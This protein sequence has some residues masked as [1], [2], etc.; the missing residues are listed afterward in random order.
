[1]VRLQSQ[2]KYFISSKVSSDPLWQRV[3]VILS[4]HETP[5]EGEHKIM[6]FIRKEKS[7]P[8]DELVFYN[9]WPVVSS[10]LSST[11]IYHK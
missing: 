9:L 10:C 7:K 2:L 6:D 11:G 4:G 1:M 8:G 5:G 3:R